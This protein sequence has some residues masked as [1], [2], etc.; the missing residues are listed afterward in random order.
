FAVQI[1]CH[2][3]G[4]TDMAIGVA[5]MLGVRL[6]N[7]FLRPYAAGSLV[8]F[9]RRWHVTLS[10]WLRDYLYIPLGGNRHGRLKGARNVLITMTLGGLWHGANWTF[11]VWGLLHGVAIAFVQTVRGLF[12]GRARLMPKWLGLALT[13]HFVTLAWVF[14]RAPDLA[15]AGRMLAA[16][17]RGSWENLGAFVPA[18]AFTILLIVVF[19]TLHRFDDHRRVKAM[20]RYL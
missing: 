13:F 2:F 3:S 5:L 18:H 12:P 11:V 1:Y 17:F 19:Y 8:D 9:W 4:Y 7:N 15:T 10:L 6:P 20:L 14:F 16:P